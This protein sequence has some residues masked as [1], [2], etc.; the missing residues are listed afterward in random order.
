MSLTVH[1]LASGSS[2]N[3]FL[4]KDGDTAI[5]VDAG[6]GIRRLTAALM[7][8]QVNPADLSAI[9]ITHEHTDHITGAVRMARRFGIPI[10]ANSLTLDRIPGAVSVPHKTIDPCE[11][12]A[13]GGLLI[14]PFRISHDAACPVGYCVHSSTATAVIATDTGMLTPEIREEAF[15]ADLLILESN[16]DEE[17]LLKGPYPWYLKRRIA[18]EHGHISNDAASSLLIDLAEAERPVSVWLAHLS[19]TN[20]SPAIALTTAEYALWRCLG[21]SMDIKVALRDV[22]SLWWRE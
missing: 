21:V 13:L 12:M 10:V 8:A 20:N 11:E 2:G 19:K 5:L 15:R 6:V 16:H 1:S 14:R 7:Q 22:P 18:S 3:S 17:M 4:I 9:F